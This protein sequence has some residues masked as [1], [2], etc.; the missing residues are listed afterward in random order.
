MDIYNYLSRQQETIPSWLK[1]YKKDDKPSFETLL[2]SRM[3]YYPGAGTD[4]QPIKTFNKSHIVHL[5]FYVDYG[6]SKEE[7]LKELSQEEA[8]KGYQLIDVVDYKKKELVPYS[9]K[10]HYQLTECDKEELKR[11]FEFYKHPPFCILLM[12]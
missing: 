5:F 12:Y 8:F 9:W 7:T 3:I 2:K 11:H 1:N 4:G 6:I 10:Q